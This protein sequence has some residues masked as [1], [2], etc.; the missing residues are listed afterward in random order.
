M[1]QDQET[2]IPYNTISYSHSLPPGPSR[3][4]RPPLCAFE[5]LPDVA[6]CLGSERGPFPNKPSQWQVRLP[7]R[8][9]PSWD[10]FVFVPFRL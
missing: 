5:L 2:D 1:F 8:Y 6:G 4:C 9:A 10:F 7:L 3:L